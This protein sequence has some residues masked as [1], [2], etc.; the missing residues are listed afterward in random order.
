MPLQAWGFDEEQ[1]FR[2]HDLLSGAE[3]AWRGEW[4]FVE[5]DPAVCPAHIFQIV[6]SEGLMRVT[7]P[8]LT[9]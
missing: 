7:P 4:N 2:V 5:L 8:N 9:L 6:D 1:S 3:Y